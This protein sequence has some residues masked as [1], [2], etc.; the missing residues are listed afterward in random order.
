MGNEAV[1]FQG[2]LS[3]HPS[4]SYIMTSFL[5]KLALVW[6]KLRWRGARKPPGSSFFI[7]TSPAFEMALYTTCFFQSYQSSQCTCRINGKPLT[8]TAVNFNRKGY[9]LT[10]YP[11]F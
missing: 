1:S 4:D 10:A 5:L 6:A 11:K 2:L 3:R 9:V 7:G 8:L